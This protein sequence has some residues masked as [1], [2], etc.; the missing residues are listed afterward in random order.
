MPGGDIYIE[1]C[2]I[3]APLELCNATTLMK[4]PQGSKDGSFYS[5]WDGKPLENLKRRDVN[6]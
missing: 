5:E 3:G 1:F 4:G 2:V 6:A